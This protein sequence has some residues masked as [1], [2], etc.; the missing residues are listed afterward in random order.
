MSITISTTPSAN[1]AAFAP[2]TIAGTTTR[3]PFESGTRDSRTITAMADSGGGFLKL[4]V[5]SQTWEDDDTIL[6]DGATTDFD[7]YNG[8]HTITA[9]TSTTITTA[10]AW[11]AATTGTKGTVY[12]MNENLYI[13]LQVINES[14]AV[15]ATL[16]TLVNTDD[17]SW[18]FDVSKPLQYEL[19]TTFTHT[20]G[21][22]DMTLQSHEYTLILYEQWQAD[23]YTTTVDAH[24][25]EPT[26][27]AHR[28]IELPTDDNFQCND[29]FADNRIMVHYINDTVDDLFFKIETDVGG[30]TS[31]AVVTGYNWH[32]GYVFTFTT[33]AKWAKITAWHRPDAIDTQLSDTIIVKKIGCNSTIIYYVN[34]YGI[35]SGYE[36]HNW[37]DTQKTIKVDK[38]TGEAWQERTLIG[39]EYVNGVYQDIR[40]II[41]SPEVY[42]EDLELVR[43]LTDSILYKSDEVNPKIKLRYDETFIQ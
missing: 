32:Y 12:R 14:A 20:A 21:A 37:D 39:K 29:H 2:V 33:S 15:I 27:I 42:D 31:T 43:V 11:V 5:S 18:S 22:V 6:I 40:D 3:N 19:A 26:T 41:T 28:T 23:D 35:Y 4:T 17:D 1:V 8:R 7:Q 16:Y 36:C 9:K 38:Y 10:T 24:V 34:R 30:T 25:T 13:K